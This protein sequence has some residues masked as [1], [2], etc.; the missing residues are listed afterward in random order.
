MMRE[1]NNL[2]T[3]KIEKKIKLWDKTLTACFYCFFASGVLLLLCC[4]LS[5]ALA[6][7]SQFLI[8]LFALLGMGSAVLTHISN[9]AI[10]ML[11]QKK[12]NTGKES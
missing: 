3:D 9:I 8:V 2:C 5:D 4:I 11:K 10:K 6:P 7:F 12:E 1:K